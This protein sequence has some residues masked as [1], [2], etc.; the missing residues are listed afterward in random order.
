MLES[1]CQSTRLTAHKGGPGIQ[2]LA[3]PEACMFSHRLIPDGQWCRKFRQKEKLLGLAIM[4]SLVE[5]LQVKVVWRCAWE[6]REA[7]W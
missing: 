4:K 7:S 1:R 3:A 5:K 6:V 2:G